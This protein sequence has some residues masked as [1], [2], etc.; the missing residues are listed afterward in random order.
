MISSGWQLK[1][2]L[3]ENAGAAPQVRL[4]KRNPKQRPQKTRC[5]SNQRIPMVH[6]RN[7]AVGKA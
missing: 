6:G 5:K 7:K 1:I 4:W 3:V 2:E